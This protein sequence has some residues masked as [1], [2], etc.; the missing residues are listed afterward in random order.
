MT[1]A[2]GRTIEPQRASWGIRPG[3]RAILG[4]VVTADVLIFGHAPGIAVA[5]LLTIVAAAIA[6]LNR[7]RASK[8]GLWIGAVAYL[9]GMMPL[10]EAPTPLGLLS[11]VLGLAVLAL[12]ASSRLPRSAVDLPAVLARFATLAPFRLAADALRAF[13]DGAVGGTGALL[14]REVLAW[15]VPGILALI[16]VLLFA[17]ANPLIEA[18]LSA[19]NLDDLLSLLDPWRVVF[20]GVVAWFVWPFLR[21]RL[22]RRRKPAEVQGPVMPRADGLIFGRAA[23]LR[24]L[25]VF[26]ALFAVQTAMDI[27]YL[28]GGVEL[29]H[30]MTYASYA[31]RGAYPLIVTALLAASFV[32]AAMRPNGAAG[33]S[34]LIRALVYVFIAQNVMLVVS[35]ILRLDLYVEVYSLTGLRVA[36]GIWMGLVA[37]GLVLIMVRI[38]LRRSNRWLVAMNLGSLGLTLYACAYVDL[39]AI[40]S[41][42]N[43]EHSYELTGQ[44]TPIDLYYLGELGPSA[45]PAI[46]LLLQ[47]AGGRVPNAAD[48][49]LRRVQLAE[50]VLSSEADWRSWSLRQSRLQAYLKGA[51]I[52]TLPTSGQN[53]VSTQ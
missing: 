13:K 51:P 45:I 4:L 48:L 29:P 49:R 31:H 44:G 11:A 8:K 23:I 20:W 7:H 27:A 21:P 40:I 19:I 18:S 16:F 2:T 6:V 1:D 43:V 25:V 14:S 38:W 35:S 17:S 39:E 36:A 46:D 9:A 12:A 26:N 24:S 32:L 52:E 37:I 34:P 22:L 28:W 50:Y 3:A 30:G 42:F 10:I 15:I 5:L 53:R 41:R 47:D 33:Q